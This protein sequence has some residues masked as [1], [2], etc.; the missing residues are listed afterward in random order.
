RQAVPSTGWNEQSLCHTGTAAGGGADF[1]GMGRGC[2]YT[3]P[4]DACGYL[5]GSPEEGSGGL[6]SLERADLSS[7]V[8][9]ALSGEVSADHIPVEAGRSQFHQYQKDRPDRM[10]GAEGFPEDRKSAGTCLKG[11]E[12]N[13]K[14][15]YGVNWKQKV[16]LNA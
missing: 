14:R 15:C 12:S 9:R 16:P 5:A 6:Q 10:A 4:P 2:Q 13:F 11:A 3:V 1:Q 8:Q 7:L